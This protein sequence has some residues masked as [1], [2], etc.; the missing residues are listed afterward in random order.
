MQTTVI[1]AERSRGR[2]ERARTDIEGV[3]V[4]RRLAVV[5]SAGLAAA[6]LLLTLSAGVAQ[7]RWGP[8][9]ACSIVD[10]P[11]NE[12][13]YALA[14]RSANDLGSIL[15]ADEESADVY[16]WNT[17]AFTSQEQWIAF[18]PKSG[19]IEMGQLEGYGI[20]CCTV[21]PFFAE[22]TPEHQW[23]IRIAEGSGTNVYAHYLIYDTEQNGIWRMYW[24]EWTEM[25]G[26][27]GWG[28]IRFGEQEAGT[29][30]G[31]ETR[32]IDNGR[33]EVARWLNGSSPWYPWN[34]SRY[35]TIVS[36]AFCRHLNQGL[37][38]EGNIEWKVGS[39]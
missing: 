4:I 31:T 20:N 9:A 12:H 27:G 24:G 19:W 33:D 36:G 32:P 1:H 18:P 16:D 35:S 22:E 29:E 30:V 8:G 11:V 25:E 2:R 6:S 28:T 15:F 13:C 37:P 5:T 7:A 23:H 17:G 10:S 39:C 34:G 38:A 26:Y 21:H 14:E 3:S